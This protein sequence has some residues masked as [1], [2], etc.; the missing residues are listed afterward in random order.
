MKYSV[1][2]VNKTEMFI[3]GYCKQN[4]DVYLRLLWLVH[5]IHSWFVAVVSVCGQSPQDKLWGGLR[6]PH[7]LWDIIIILISITN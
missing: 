7:N 5:S 6:L 1:Y 3:S 2:K 4:R